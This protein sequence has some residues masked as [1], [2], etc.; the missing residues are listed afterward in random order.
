[1]IALKHAYLICTLVPT[2]IGFEMTYEHTPLL[3]GLLL[4]IVS[5]VGIAFIAKHRSVTVLWT[6][7]LIL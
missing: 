5:K 3:C 7:C 4:E 1:M 6:N 2:V